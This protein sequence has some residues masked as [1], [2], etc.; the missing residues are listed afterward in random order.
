[1]FARA[2]GVRCVLSVYLAGEFGRS[3]DQKRRDNSAKRGGTAEQ[4]SGGSSAEEI[5]DRRQFGKA[6]G[7]AARRALGLLCYAGGIL[8]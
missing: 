1:M 5:G 8:V 7:Q 2:G 6:R 3:D 4:F